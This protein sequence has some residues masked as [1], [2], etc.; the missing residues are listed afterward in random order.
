MTDASTSPAFVPPPDLNETA[1]DTADKLTALL[2]LIGIMAREQTHRAADLYD[3]ARQEA[4]I[5][6]WRVLVTQPTRPNAYITKAARRAAADVVRRRPMTG[7]PR[8]QGK[9]DATD[10]ATLLDPETL[11]DFSDPTS[12]HAPD[13]VDARETLRPLIRAV[14]DFTTADRE[15]IFARFWQGKTA[16]EIADERGVTARAI[17][18]RW[19]H[20]LRPVLV[21]NP[22]ILSLWALRN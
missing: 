14:R 11:P 15:Y 19:T 5:A 1:P 12:S 18:H 20:V 3:D 13:E 22:E 7:E 2:P 8:H 16:A 21:R 9:Q 4:L 17:E 10:A 6:A